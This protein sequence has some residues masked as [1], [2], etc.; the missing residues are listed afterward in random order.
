MTGLWYAD[1]FNLVLCSWLMVH[2][3]HAESPKMACVCAIVVGSA[4]TNLIHR[5]SDAG[6]L[7]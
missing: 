4:I 7:G 6:F 3:L 2:F 5:F 1:I